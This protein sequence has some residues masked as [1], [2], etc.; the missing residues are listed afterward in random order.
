MPETTT[1]NRSRSR[2]ALLAGVLAIA[3]LLPLGLS[4]VG[5]VL[6]LGGG[7]EPLLERPQTEQTT[8]VWGM[9]ASEMRLHHWEHLR[10]IREEV[11]RFGDRE[12]DGLNSCKT[13]HVSRERFCDRCHNAV[14]LKPDCF[15]CHY[16]P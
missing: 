7:P 6:A 5:R 4:L 10:E 14:S 11:V 13:C 3:L 8:C 2:R 1:D 12:K 16:Y 15:E 9:D